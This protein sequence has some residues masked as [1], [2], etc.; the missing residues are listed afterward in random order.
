MINNAGVV[1]DEK[2]WQSGR[3]QVGGCSAQK[4]KT[5]G[6]TKQTQEA[7]DKINKHKNH[8]VG[9]RKHK[10]GQSTILTQ[11]GMH[12]GNKVVLV[13]NR[14]QLIPKREFGAK[15]FRALHVGTSTLKSILHLSGSQCGEASTGKICSYFLVLESVRAA[16]CCINWR[17]VATSGQEGIALI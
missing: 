9:T 13:G 12:S 16:A 4:Q 3:G 6:M 15:L 10:N 1:G 8:M 5:H 17:L 2:K 14:G 7:H 11:G